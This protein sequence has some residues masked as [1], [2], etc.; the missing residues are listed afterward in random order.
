[1]VSGRWGEIIATAWLRLHGWRIVA[2]N[3]RPPR[4]SGLGEVDI[5]ARRGNLLIFAEVKSRATTQ[6]ALTAML[7]RQQDR[8]RQAAR[9]FLSLHSSL[10]KRYS[11]R[12][13]LIL[14]RPWRLPVHIRDAWPSEPF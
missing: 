3:W 5:I 9:V 10:A 7:P 12:F 11:W 2:R 13:D 6:A 1:M 14:I 4:H 8:Q